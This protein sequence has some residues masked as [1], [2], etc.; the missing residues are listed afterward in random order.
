MRIRELLLTLGL[1]LTLVSCQKSS[2]DASLTKSSDSTQIFE[3]V[4]SGSSGLD[5]SNDLIE[6]DSLNYLTYAYMYMGGGVAAGDINNDGLVDLYFTGN[7]VPNK[8]F[9]NKGNLQFEDISDAAG[10]AGDKRWFTGVT[11]ADVNGDGY[12]DI[13]CSVGGKFQ[14]KENLLFINNGDLTFTEKAK[15][16]GVDDPGNSVQSTFFDYDRDGDLDLYVGNYPPTNFNAPNSYYGFKMANTTDLETDNLYRNDGDLFTQVTDEAGLRSFG[17]TNSVTVGDLNSDGW[18]DLYVSND[19]KVPDYLWINNQDGTFSEH[20][21]ELTDQV[22]LYGMGVDIADINNDKLLDIIQMDMTPGDNRR[23]KANMAGMNPDL[24]WGTVNAGFHYQYMHNQLQLNNGN[25]QDSLPVFSNVARLAG[26][27]TTDWSWGPLIIDLDNDGWKDIFISNGTRREINNKDYFNELAKQ[28]LTKDML[29]EKTLDIPAEKID[30]FVFKNNGDLTFEK[31]NE[32]WGLTFEGWSNGCLYADLDND[33]DLEIVI[34]NIDDQASL[35]EN[36]SSENNNYLTLSFEGTENNKNG[37]GVKALVRSNGLEQFQEMTLSR[38]FQSSVDPRLHFGLGTADKIEELAVTWPDGKVQKFNNLEANQFLVVNHANATDP[39]EKPN[40]EAE[41]KLFLTVN[42][43]D[44][45]AR[46]KHVENVYDDFEDQV[47]LPHRT[48]SF[49]PDISVGDL[50]GDGL[51]DFVVGGAKNNQTGVYFQKEKGFEKQDIKDIAYDSDF[52]DL[53]SLIFDADGDGDN[54]LYIVSGGSEAPAGS[55]QLQDRLYVN[56]GNG[57]FKRSASALP[58]MLTSGSRVKAFD[59]DKDGD[60]DLFVG[61]R[62][63][64]KDYPLPTDSYILENVSDTGKPAFRDATGEIAPALSQIGMVT[65]ASWTDYDQD[66]WVDLI[67]VGEWMPITIL[68][69]NRG[70]FEDITKKLDLD[71]SN[72]WWFSI[73][74]GDFDKDGDPDFVLGNLGLN[75]KYQASEE[76]TFDVYLND[77]DKNDKN[78]IVLSYYDEG[79]KFPVRG[80][81]CSSEQIPAIKKKFKD[82]DAFAVATLEDVYTKKDLERSLHYQVR[83]FASIYLENREGEFVIHKLPNGAQLSSINQII[84]RDVDQDGNL[85]LITAG[86]LYGSEVETPRNDAGIGLYLRGDGKGGFSPVP[87]RESGLYVRGDTKDLAVIRIKNADYLIA[88]KNDEYLQFIRIG[89]GS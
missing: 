53:G 12:L 60:L 8:L 15:E 47:L 79:E 64:P 23:S 85:D 29:L 78:D 44:I 11:M 35:F 77:F 71:A 58:R 46:H 7:R 45:V 42:D 56:D 51:E 49:G 9:L 43:P 76:E 32:K 72:G 31:M 62:L 25:L 61:G 41:E 10:V 54:D 18:P 73:A 17:L 80:R 34:N 33:G 84:P 59:Y 74:E 5:F 13:Y 30:N 1:V 75:Y 36:H 70:S 66:G 2:D 38:G 82:Y 24:F 48:S 89:K 14:P 26:V 21:R 87:A 3:S 39:L 22:A 86:N 28:R 16:Y 4:A 57:E 67:V 83:S 55:E 40:S 88:A 6:T 50:N 68:R 65:D 81:Q 20:I 63:T 69:N 37:L 27:A 52:E 19:F